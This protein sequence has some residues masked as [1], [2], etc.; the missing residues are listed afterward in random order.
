MSTV[1]SADGTTIAY[2]QSGSGVL[3]LYAAAAGP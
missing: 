2:E 1:T 3:A